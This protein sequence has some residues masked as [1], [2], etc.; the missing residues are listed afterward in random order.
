MNIEVFITP[1]TW[2]QLSTD[3]RVKL[4]KAFDMKRSTSPR[5]VT[6]RGVTK[7]ESDG[8]TV[9]D[10]RKMNV[11]SM[12]QWLGFTTIDPNADI[13]ALL[14]MCAD[15]IEHPEKLE[16]LA[17]VS[18]AV[19]GPWCDSCDSKGVRHKKTCPKNTNV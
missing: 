2:L 3:T 10:L 18:D 7:V 8:F 4:A 9:D 1:Y 17:K 16:E 6:E 19:S 14:G 12:Q 5:C 15:R 11:E 13:N